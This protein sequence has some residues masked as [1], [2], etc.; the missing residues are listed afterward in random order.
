M[1]E[2]LKRIKERIRKKREVNHANSDDRM[3]YYL[4]KTRSQ[5]Q[6]KKEK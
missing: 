5:K 3:Q 1:F 2:F 6:Q 4:H